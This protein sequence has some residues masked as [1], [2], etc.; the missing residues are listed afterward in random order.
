[1]SGFV[2]P[3]G[4]PALMGILNVTPDSFSD[5]GR[6]WDVSAAVSRGVAMIEE[7]ADLVDVGGE[8]TRPNAEPVDEEEESRRVLPVVAALAR[9]G[10]PVSV[11]TSKAVVAKR[12]LQEGA[13][14]VNDVSA[15]AD[16]DMAS[17]CATAGCCVCLM[18]RRGDPRT[19]QR[20][21]VYGDVVEEVLAYLH[22]RVAY[23]EQ[24]GV[25][26]ERIWIDPGIG[27]GK[28]PEGNFALLAA[29][30]RLAATGYPV[31]IGVSRKSFLAS[32]LDSPRPPEDRVA[33]SVA[34]QVVAQW[35]G[36]RILRVHDVRAARDAIVVTATIARARQEAE[37]A[38]R[39]QSS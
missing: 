30:A 28:S 6:Y 14:V 17:V 32:V 18:H 2:L 24:A 34:C 33:A 3:E 12:A 38:R 15:F 11:D 26:R 23:A 21:T 1:M 36:A 29:T 31:L 13:L 19:M 25:A 10:I 7:G 16:R 8:S 5:G 9:K 39:T 37:A 20:D 35:S 27:F 22:A 4:R